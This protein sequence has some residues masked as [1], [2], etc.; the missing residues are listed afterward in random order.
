MID[1]VIEV[2]VDWDG[3][4]NPHHHNHLSEI[5]DGNSKGF[6]NYI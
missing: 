4:R 3:A 6:A 2:S 1:T 5:I